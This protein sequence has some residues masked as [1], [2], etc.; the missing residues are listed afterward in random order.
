MSSP[1]PKINGY[2]KSSDDVR[3]FY[4]AEGD[5]P[6]LVFC[7]GL[8]CSSLHWKY[9]F[10]HFKQ[11]H[12]AIWMDYR[13]HHYSEVPR[14]LSS[15][16]LARIAR[17]V[18]ELTE[19]LKLPPA[20]FLGHSMG[21][22]IV[23]EIARQAPEKVSSLVL[24]N[25]TSRRPFETMLRVNAIQ[26][27]VDFANRIYKLSPDLM[28]K[29]WVYNARSPVT[30]FLIGQY[31]FNTT[32]ADPKDIDLYVRRISELDPAMFF[33]VVDTYQT[34]DATPWLHTLKMPTLVIGGERDLITPIEEQE[35]LAQL[36]PGA[37]FE[38]IQH[39][40]HCTQ[41]DLPEL[42]NLKI[43]RFLRTLAR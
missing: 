40:S 12:R 35:L 19:E 21:V 10:E 28:R 5:G 31:G 38:R 4:H 8:V 6:P 1:V 30:R 3:L 11:S 23:L 27:A 39:G 37:L 2:F 33:N 7:Y 36:I 13:G 22:N 15:L 24:A 20:V 43:E 26:S 25:G 34:Y 42:V 16:S 18:I 17:D 41:L 14:D 32:L 9:Q 29:V